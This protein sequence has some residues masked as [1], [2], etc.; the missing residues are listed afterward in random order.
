MLKCVMFVATVV[1]L[2]DVVAECGKMLLCSFEK[3]F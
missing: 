2:V 3:R 1:V